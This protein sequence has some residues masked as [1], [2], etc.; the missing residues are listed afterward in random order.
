MNQCDIL[1]ETVLRDVVDVINNVKDVDMVQL[2]LAKDVRTGSIARQ[3]SNL[4]LVFPVLASTSL[5]IQTVSIISKAIER[6]CVALLQILFSAVAMTKAKDTQEFIS[7][8]HSNLN[9]GLTI[10]EFLDALDKLNESGDLTITDMDAYKA[11]QEDLKN[12]NYHLD[13]SFNESSIGD[14]YIQK[15]YYGRTH[16]F[17]EATPTPAD[18]LIERISDKAANEI[19]YAIKS[20][21]KNNDASIV[22]DKYNKTGP[23]KDT[24]EYFKNQLL[25]QDV[26]KAN[27]LMPTLM[28]V[29]FTS[30]SDNEIV[31]EPVDGVIGVKAKIYPIDS[32][33]IV[34]RLA[35][36]VSDSNGL[37]SFIRATTREISFFKDFV[38]AIDK[39]KLD[40]ISVAKE[41]NNA[42]IFKL[43]E[44]RATKNK[45]MSMLK[46]NDASAIT[47][48]VISQEEVDY[49]MKY[50]NIDMQ[51]SYV[52][53]TLMEKYNL[54]DIVLADESL[55]VARFL[56]DDGDTTYE[57]M[58]FDSLEKEAKDSS[59]KKVVN[60]MSKLSR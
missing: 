33:D 22:K 23:T 29:H 13:Y 52:T 35:S 57:A 37:F 8:F 39:A 48:L 32:M 20:S 2:R 26:Q 53:R 9:K 41:S 19:K 27:E 38:F 47:S 42:K 3:A 18:R 50:H 34:N 31:K 59:Y 36:K 14:Y 54:M 49:L 28:M 44:R 5:S 21:F 24:V 51:K 25:P 46:K 15:D 4:I 17:K 58:T 43:L 10:D 1:H 55:E 12:L 45:M 7:L 11:V 56:Y 40:G 16:V 60:L 6:K 30:L